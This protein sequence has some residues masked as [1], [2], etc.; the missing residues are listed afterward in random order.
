MKRCNLTIGESRLDGMVDSFIL[1]SGSQNWPKTYSLPTL[2][3]FCRFESI[4]GNGRARCWLG[5]QVVKASWLFEEHAKN[6]CPEQVWQPAI[7]VAKRHQMV[8]SC[9]APVRT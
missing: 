5:L 7:Q 1:L 8:I 6:S 4:R 3:A 2:S 9:C